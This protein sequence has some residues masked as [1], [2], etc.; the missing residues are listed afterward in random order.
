M[1]SDP[2]SIF[3]T[4]FGGYGGLRHFSAP[5]VEGVAGLL[6]SPNR[7]LLVYTPIMLFALIG[8]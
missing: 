3:A 1:P 4:A 6:V 8:V 7:G 5:L 2:K